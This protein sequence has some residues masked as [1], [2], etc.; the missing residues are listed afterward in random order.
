[1]TYDAVIQVGNPE[2]KLVPGMTA[3]VT[4]L[5]AAPAESILK[6]PNAALRLKLLSDLLA[7]GTSTSRPLAANWGLFT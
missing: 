2:L 5:T 7:G 6:L 3:N 1:M 4:I